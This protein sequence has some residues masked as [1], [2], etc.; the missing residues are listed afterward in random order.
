V[1]VLLSVRPGP[2]E[3]RVRRLLGFAVGISLTANLVTDFVA[4]RA[5]FGNFAPWWSYPSIAGQVLGAAALLI[6]P[7]LSRG[8]ALSV[9]AVAFATFGLVSVSLI[10]PAAGV[11]GLPDAAGAAWP[12]R[13]LSSYA[14]PVMFAVTPRFGWGYLGLLAISA[15]FARLL[16]PATMNPKQALEDSVVNTTVTVLLTIFFMLLVRAGRQLDHAAD[17]AIAA[18]RRDSA[19]EATAIERRRVELLA[20]DEILHVLRVVAMGVR[21]P[22]VSPAGLARASLDRL[23]T[24]ESDDDSGHGESDLEGTE[25]LNRLRGLV[26]AIAPLATFDAEDLGGRVVPAPVAI[27]LLDATGETLRNSMLHAG[28]DDLAVARSVRVRRAGG[29]LTVSIVDDGRG[30]RPREVPARRLGVARSI[31]A[32]MQAVPGGGATVDSS[33]GAGTRVELTWQ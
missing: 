13:V 18:V 1:S 3:L 10:V 7:W 5:Q 22:L 4:Y 14:M 27:A 24:L 19:A 28:D 11:G 9:V 29:I 2:A 26:T 32:R 8:R 30:F 33:P 12:L 6:V 25:F 21:S 31:V 23:A 17:A 20:H 15:F 16:T